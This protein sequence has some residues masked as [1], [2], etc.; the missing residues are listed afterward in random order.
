[1]LET[2]NFSPNL[3]SQFPSGCQDDKLDASLGFEQVIGSHPLNDGESEGNGLARARLVPGN[4]ILALV[5][6]LVGLGLDGEECR[7]ALVLQDLYR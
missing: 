5:D 4:H 6:M 2:L 1:M 3:N 7:Y